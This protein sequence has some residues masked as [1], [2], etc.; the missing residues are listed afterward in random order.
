LLVEGI[1]Q[2][3]DTRREGV[4]LLVEGITKCQVRDSRRE[5]VNLLVEGISKSQVGDV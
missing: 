5:V 2:L 4:N 3:D 1:C